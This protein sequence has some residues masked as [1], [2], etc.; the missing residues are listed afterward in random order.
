[1]PVDSATGTPHTPVRDEPSARIKLA[2]R[3]EE[4]LIQIRTLDG[5]DGFL[6]PKTFT[7]LRSA[8]VDGPIILINV[9]KN[10]TF[11]VALV[12]LHSSDRIVPVFLPELSYEG[13]EQMRSMLLISLQKISVRRRQT[14]ER[15]VFIDPAPRHPLFDVLG[16]LWSIVVSPILQA[17]EA[18]V[19]I[20][21]HIK[22]L[23]H[24]TW[25]TTGAL[26]FLP[27]HA[28][29]IYDSPDPRDKIFNRVVS[30]YTPTISSLLRPHA[31]KQP[32]SSVSL[33][34]PS[35]K[36]LIVSQPDTP[37]HSP[38]PSTLQEAANV[39]KQFSDGETTHLNHTDATF[40][41]VM[42]EMRNHHFPFIHLACH[43][44][45]DPEDP[46][47]SAFALYHGKLHLSDIMSHSVAGA[48][49]AFLSACQT[50]KGDAKLPE[51]SV[52]LAAGM[53]TAGYKAVIGTMWSIID[54]DA[55]LVAD[56]VY[57]RL[58]GGQCGPT[59]WEGEK[60][61]VAYALHEAVKELREEV[62]E[63]DF[64]RWVPFVHFG[65]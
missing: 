19:S 16:A 52:H 42:C 6:K 25:C 10:L 50:A 33:P 43:G 4:L 12:V 51:E 48:E 3:Y 1:M 60:M 46:R 31:E 32:T 2:H 34:S 64:A 18:E 37:G 44:M 36:I 56:G 61:D 58:I 28:A 45:Q 20:I 21:V 7:E 62:G 8:C 63:V 39:R 24:V 53:L 38:L 17:I 11:T 15:G 29:G 59:G 26:S 54:E 65:S 49:L 13:A 9:V 41:A 23:P 57:R 27:I 47:K 40:D 14:A 22:T 5:F 55:P 35:K 30:S